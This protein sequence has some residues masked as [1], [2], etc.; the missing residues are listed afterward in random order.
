VSLCP[1]DE[2][3]CKNQKSPRRVR[4]GQI[5]HDTGP[6]VLLNTGPASETLIAGAS[7]PRRKHRHIMRIERH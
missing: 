1:G 6:L 5:N 3:I 4:G 2:V 7:N